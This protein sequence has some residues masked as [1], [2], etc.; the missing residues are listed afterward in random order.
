MLPDMQDQRATSGRC[1]PCGEVWSSASPAFFQ[2]CHPAPPAPSGVT[3]AVGRGR[4]G[5]RG[6][7]KPAGRSVSAHLHPPHLLMGRPQP[8]EMSRKQELSPT[9]C[10][11]SSSRRSWGNGFRSG[12]SPQR[13]IVLFDRTAPRQGVF[14]KVMVT[15]AWTG[16]AIGVVHCGT[17]CHGPA[18]HMRAGSV[19]MHSHPG[20]P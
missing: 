7:L 20:L 2:G 5:P 1:L 12:L 16:V 4:K 15:Q 17:I 18:V 10:S 3:G 8:K 14:L 11:A 19:P 13:E 6:G 9:G